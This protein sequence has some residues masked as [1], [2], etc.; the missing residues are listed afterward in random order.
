M[1]YQIYNIADEIKVMNLCQDIVHLEMEIE[2]LRLKIGKLQDQKCEAEVAID[3][4]REAA[5]ARAE[6]TSLESGTTPLPTPP[7]AVP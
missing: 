3:R 4:I 2:K 6:S 5:R 7:P 1:S